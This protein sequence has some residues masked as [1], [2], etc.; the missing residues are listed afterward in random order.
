MTPHA[1]YKLVSGAVA[2]QSNG[3]AP[4][5]VRELREALETLRHAL[6]DRTLRETR[7]LFTDTS[8]LTQGAGSGH[9]A[10]Q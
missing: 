7:E 10:R 1:A 5:R 2:A 3:S 4:E 9:D 6:L 8:R